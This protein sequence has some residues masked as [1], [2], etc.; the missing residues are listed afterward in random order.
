ME[1]LES[2]EEAEVDG[3]EE[4]ALLLLPAPAAAAVVAVG[5]E[6]LL[7]V[8]RLYSDQGTGGSQIPISLLIS[9]KSCS[10]LSSQ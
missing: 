6:E 2:E 5:L 10:H 8:F 4:E 1:E 7:L 3:E 9:P